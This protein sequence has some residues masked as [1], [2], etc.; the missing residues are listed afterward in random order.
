MTPTRLPLRALIFLA[1][2]FAW[3]AAP[4]AEPRAAPVPNA[5]AARQLPPETVSP[6]P[7]RRQPP[8][9]LGD[10]EALA[11]AHQ[12]ALTQAAAAVRAAHGAWVQAGKYPNPKLGY[13][14]EEIGSEG[15]SGFQGA[16]VEQEL[17]TAGKLRLDQNAL[18]QEVRLRRFEL[19]AMRLRV[20]AD[21]RSGYFETLAAAAALDVHR[22]LADITREELR[23][24][25]EFLKAQE[26]PRVDVLLARV[27]QQIAQVALTKAEQ[28]YLAAWRRL[29]AVVGLPDLQPAPLVG[30]LED[31]SPQ[32]SWDDALARLRAHSPELA[33]AAAAVA[34]ARWELRRAQVEPLPNVE[35]GVELL[36]D[37]AAAED[38]T[39]VA[40][41]V[42][43]PLFNRNQGRIAQ[44]GAEVAAQ[45]AAARRTELRL[46]H[47]LA[48]VFERYAGA[49]E[50][51]QRYAGRVLPDAEEALE[52]LSQA[53]RQGESGFSTVLIAQRSYYQARLAYLD[54]LRELRQSAAAIDSL[55]LSESL[56]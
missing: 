31:S 42:P 11:L 22:Q 43:L 51:V 49:R 12:P 17:V 47:Q 5:A 44:A 54:A 20:L 8:L 1:L 24:A 19:E 2:Q 7:A 55:L 45:L 6:P 35:V 13:I 18:C 37:N 26:K 52:L 14:G 40:V 48:E 32:L 16:L 41:A 50:Q 4:A 25:E 53:Y 28:R 34:R 23:L 27:E 38:V 15:S 30:R 29:S 46:Q 10:L 9:A 39:S 21:V 3:A 56:K 33:A 36:H